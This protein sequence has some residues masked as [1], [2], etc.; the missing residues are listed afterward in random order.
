MFLL[1]ARVL[2]FS[3]PCLLSALASL[4]FTYTVFYSKF[5]FLEASGV[6]CGP[7]ALLPLEGGLLRGRQNACPAGST[8]S[9]QFAS[10]QVFRICLLTE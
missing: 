10:Q 3:L 9:I 8:P 6:L 7:V 4:C 1:I 5:H 2:F